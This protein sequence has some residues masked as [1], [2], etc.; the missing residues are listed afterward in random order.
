MSFLTS[1][2][3]A[4]NK[5]FVPLTIVLVGRRFHRMTGPCMHWEGPAVLFNVFQLNPPFFDL[6]FAIRNAL[7]KHG[8]LNTQF[9]A[10]T[11]DSIRAITQV[12]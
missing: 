12:E 1:G 8:K 7:S 10:I 11:T 2:I 9:H 3:E 6:P 4:Q 5:N